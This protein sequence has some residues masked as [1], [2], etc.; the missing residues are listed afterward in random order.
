MVKQTTWILHLL[1]WQTLD[2]PESGVSL[3]YQ[4][5]CISENDSQVFIEVMRES[6]I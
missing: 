4:H 2:M 5:S 3:N 6:L 1:K